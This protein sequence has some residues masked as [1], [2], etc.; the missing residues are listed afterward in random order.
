MGASIVA[1]MDTSPILDAAE[2][3]FNLVPLSIEL[4][5]VRDRYLAIG[6]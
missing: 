2:H 3:V 4:G 1:G 5:V 6:P